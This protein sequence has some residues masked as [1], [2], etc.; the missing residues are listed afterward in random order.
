[1][2]NA[3]GYKIYPS[4]QL[5]SSDNGRFVYQAVYFIQDAQGVR[6][7]P[8]TVAGQYESAEEAAAAAQAA[9]EKLLAQM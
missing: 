1:M 8:I 3:S 7:D 2:S 9:G 5:E 6:G 4:C